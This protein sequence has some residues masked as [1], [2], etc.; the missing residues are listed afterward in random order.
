VNSCIKWPNDIYVSDKKICGILIE[1][2]IK[3][4]QIEFCIAGIGINVNQTVFPED[5]NATSL[6]RATG[7]NIFKDS[8]L[9]IFCSKF[10]K[11]YL[12][13]KKDITHLNNLYLQ[14]LKGVG[15]WQLFEVKN[16]KISLLIKGVDDSGQLITADKNGNI[17]KWLSGEL[18]WINE[19]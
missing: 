18:Q 15:K 11:N 3:N 5:I 10:E 4:Q 7:K 16:K 9:Q 13:L 12:K 8:V 14:K 6:K 2:K 17:Q 19:S 1:N